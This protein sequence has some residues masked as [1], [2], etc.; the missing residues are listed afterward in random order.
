MTNGAA[1]VAEADADDA[2]SAAEV[3]PA[4]VGVPVADARPAALD[5]DE[6]AEA[7]VA[8]VLLADEESAVEVASSLAAVAVD[9]ADTATELAP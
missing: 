3:P 1:L 9:T 8:A 7:A 2:L 6:T 4:V 5:E